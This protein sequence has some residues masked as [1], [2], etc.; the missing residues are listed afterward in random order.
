MEKETTPEYWSLVSIVALL[1]TIVYLIGGSGDSAT[2]AA[3]VFA[4][5]IYGYKNKV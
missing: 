5:S 1:I 2:A 3:I 4:T